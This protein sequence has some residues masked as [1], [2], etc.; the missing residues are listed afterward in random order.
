MLLEVTKND[1]VSSFF[2]FER[3]SNYKENFA[4]SLGVFELPQT[5][6]LYHKAL[7]FIGEFKKGLKVDV[8]E[9][10]VM[11]EVYEKTISE[12]EV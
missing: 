8:E 7:A 11:A 5:W 6:A 4:N 9:F 12:M 2:K 1:K 3:K 10:R